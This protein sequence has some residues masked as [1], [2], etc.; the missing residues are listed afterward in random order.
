MATTPVPEALIQAAA[1]ALLRFPDIP[2]DARK[3]LE[4]Y[5]QGIWAHCATHDAPSVLSRCGPFFGTT[6]PWMT[7]LD[8]RGACSVQKWVGKYYGYLEKHSKLIEINASAH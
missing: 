7:L 2:D 8:M 3:Q 4:G 1:D 5:L 6:R